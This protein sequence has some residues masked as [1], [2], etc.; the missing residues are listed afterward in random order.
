MP[1]FVEISPKVQENIF[2]G[3]LPCMGMAAI[4]CDLDYLCTF[5]F[6]LFI[7][8]SYKIWL[9]LAKQFQSRKSLTIMVIYMYTAPG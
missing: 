3:F 4:L 2:E 9:L 7:D 5:R 8:A 1:S 6:P